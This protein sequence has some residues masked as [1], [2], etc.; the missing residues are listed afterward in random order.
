AA[1]GIKVSCTFPNGGGAEK[2]CVNK[3]LFYISIF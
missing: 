3:R 1:I 2:G